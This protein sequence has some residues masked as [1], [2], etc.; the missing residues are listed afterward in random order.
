MATT[1]QTFR[2]TLAPGGGNNVAVV[3]PGD[4]VT[5]FG[6]GK[7]VPVVV[8]I[9]GGHRYR[10]TIA[11]MGGRFVISF[12]SET[13][14]ATGRGAREVGEAELQP[15]ARPRRFGH[16]CE[17]RRDAGQTR[18]RS[19]H[20][21]AELIVVGRDLTHAEGGTFGTTTTASESVRSSP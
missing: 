4:V 12:N 17:G 11:S 9:D 6:R 1:T 14:R 16:E 5:A 8:T 7:R 13:R 2:T 10:S 3:V 21:P 19:A 15:P 20:R 18:R